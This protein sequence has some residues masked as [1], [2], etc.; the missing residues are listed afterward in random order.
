MGQISTD[1]MTN[2]GEFGFKPI[3]TGFRVIP[4][5][6]QEGAQCQAD[7]ITLGAGRAYL[8]TFHATVLL[9]ATMIVIYGPGT[10]RKSSLRGRDH[11]KVVGGPV[12]PATV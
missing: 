8:S 6:P 3:E 4:L 11:C 9:D 2:N 5:Q 12:V 1:S 7:R 10:V